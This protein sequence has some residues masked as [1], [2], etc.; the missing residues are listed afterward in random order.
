MSKLDCDL[1]VDLGDVPHFSVVSLA[2]R[3]GMSVLDEARLVIAT[4]RDIDFEKVL[5]GDARLTLRNGGEATRR[6]SLKIGSADFLGID[7]G[8]LRFAVHLHAAPWLLTHTQNLRKFRDQSAE[9]IVSAVLDEG[10]IAHR[11]NLTRPTASRSFCVQYRESNLAFVQ[12][13]LEFEGIYFTFDEEGVMVLEDKSSAAPDVAGKTFFELSEAAG[14]LTHGEYG[15]HA[16]RKKSAVVTGKFTTGDFNWKK[17]K[18]ALLE[19]A[20]AEKDADLEVYEHPSGFREPSEGAHL[21]QI[22]LEARRVAASL[23]EGKGSVPSFA[24]ARVFMFGGNAGAAFSGEHLLVALEHRFTSSTHGEAATRTYENSFKTLS[25][26]VPFRPA[27]VTPVPKVLGTHTAMVRGPAG[28]EIHTDRHGRHKVQFHW[29]REAVS[30][31]ADSRWIRALQESSTSMALAR[32]GWEVNVGYIHGDPDRPVGLSRHINGVMTPTYAQPANQ[33]VMTIKTPSSPYTGGFNELK[34]DDVAGSQLFYLQAERDYT[35]LVKH[36]KSEKVGNDETHSIGANLARAVSRDQDVGIGV[37]SVTQVGE[38]L[39]LAVGGNRTRTLGGNETVKIGD[40]ASR[41]TGA[42]ESEV[43]GASRV[44]VAGGLGP[45]GSASSALEGAAKSAG[46]ALASGGGIAGAM[47]SAK[48]SAAGMVSHG[49]ISRTT[50]KAIRRAVGGAFVS[51]SGDDTTLSVTLA[52][53]E[54]VGGNKSTTAMTGGISE[55]VDGPLT[56]TVG[57][58][59][60]RTAKSDM[61]VMSKNSQIEVA[62]DA[63]YSAG[64]K[65][66][67]SGKVIEIDAPSSLTLGSGGLQIAFDPGSIRMNGTVRFVADKISH[68]GNTLTL[69]TG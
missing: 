4:N 17:P 5:R 51:V 24:P 14:S 28:A 55:Q 48:S 19:S 26:N 35:G 13:L 47:A 69:T 62:T 52:Y 46:M 49:T 8:A 36:D 40:T 42:N 15:V 6:W 31:D 68:T 60:M 45:S 2:L 29:D 3:E 33:T 53:A 7:G 38:H 12:R 10:K 59:V 25:R 44:T 43:V 56:I 1:E 50:S 58:S 61:T 18:L 27:V 64:K 16:L 63:A 67:V 23:F 21:A 30:T 34:L 54:T 11:W 57:G 20:S 9:A 65:L 41:S 66:Q 22:R 39:Q 32:V 37:D